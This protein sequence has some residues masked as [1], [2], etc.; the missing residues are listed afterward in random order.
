MI[1]SVRV[2]RVE[3]T[4]TP[5]A[6]IFPFGWGDITISLF[7]LSAYSSSTP[8]YTRTEPTIYPSILTFPP[9]Q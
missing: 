2:A 3:L 9:P 4:Y 8:C 5:S 6:A 1:D 7:S